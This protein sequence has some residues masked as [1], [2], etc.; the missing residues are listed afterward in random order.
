M[1]G[2]RTSIQV[3][4]ETKERLVKLGKKDETYDDIIRRLLDQQG[5]NKRKLKTTPK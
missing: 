3:T 1:K 5:R 2:K 4:I